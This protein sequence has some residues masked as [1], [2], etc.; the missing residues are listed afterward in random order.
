M[1]PSE[2]FAPVPPPSFPQ[3]AETSPA[4]QLAKLRDF[5]KDMPTSPNTA[6]YEEAVNRMWR[7]KYIRIYEDESRG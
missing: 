2:I 3:P 4:T 6:K 7:N 5:K 1:N